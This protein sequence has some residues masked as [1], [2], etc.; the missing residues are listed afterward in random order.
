MQSTNLKPLVGSVF[1]RRPLGA[2]GSGASALSPRSGAEK[3][4][5]PAVKRRIDNLDPGSGIGASSKPKGKS[6][7]LRSREGISKTPEIPIPGPMQTVRLGG[8]RAPADLEKEDTDWREQISHENEM[9]VAS[10]T[11]EERERERQEILERFGDGIGEILR[12]AKANR[13]AMSKQESDLTTDLNEGEQITWIS[14][15][16]MFNPVNSACVI[17]DTQAFHPN[18]CVRVARSA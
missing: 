10:M 6:S 4:G 16:L 9:K 1:E 3:T 8:P 12:K 5:F 2:N 13:L 11:D 7:F 18:Q 14:F 17:R 15:H